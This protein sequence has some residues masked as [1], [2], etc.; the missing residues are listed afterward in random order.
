MLRITAV[1]LP[2]L[3]TPVY[4][5]LFP[6]VA[7]LD[8]AEKKGGSLAQE[9]CVGKVFADSADGTVCLDYASAVAFT[10]TGESTTFS[11]LSCGHFFKTAKERDPNCKIYF[12]DAWGTTQPVV[13]VISRWAPKPGDPFLDNV[14]TDI[15]LYQL[16]NPVQ[17]NSGFSIPEPNAEIKNIEL[18]SIAYGFAIPLSDPSKSKIDTGPFYMSGKYLIENN[19]LVQYYK[20]DHIVR[21][22][23][24]SPQGTE[25][26]RLWDS[27]SQPQT[28][29]HD[30]GSVW[31]QKKTDGQP[32][33]ELWAL[34]SG[35]TGVPPAFY[36][37]PEHLKSR[38]GLSFK[39]TPFKIEVY[40][41][42]D[43]YSKPGYIP[44]SEF[45]TPLSMNHAWITENIK[46]T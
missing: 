40:D 16:Q 1:I 20:G 34:T 27:T 28:F 11:V 15:A 10:L 8:E 37:Q 38:T 43:L 9:L 14:A 26:W 36:P 25:R 33:Y 31:F 13:S 45:F 6:D 30:S 24:S 29:I 3:F 18:E 7:S 35:S 42:Y 4:A 2:M 22:I 19:R 5:G 39:T 21:L 44:Y 41:V 12:M 32:G 17:C 46:K 23:P